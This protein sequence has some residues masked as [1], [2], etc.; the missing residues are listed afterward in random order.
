MPIALDAYKLI[1]ALKDLRV[2]RW[3]VLDSK[4]AESVSPEGKEHVKVLATQAALEINC[5]CKFPGEEKETAVYAKHYV[6][7]DGKDVIKINGKDVEMD[8]VDLKAAV[9]ALKKTVDCKYMLEYIQEGTRH[10]LQL[11][12]RAKL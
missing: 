1:K 10:T 6:L 7:E 8:D 2:I 9:A 3:G 12:S 4:M 5:K 11:R